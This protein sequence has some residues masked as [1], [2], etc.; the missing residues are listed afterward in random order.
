VS[1]PALPLRASLPA[2]PLRKLFE[3][4]PIKVSAPDPP[5]AFSM[6]ISL[7]IPSPIATPVV[8]LML[9]KSSAV[10]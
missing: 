7:S 10:E 1:L 2:P 3:E 6:E 4:L 5:A 8:R 9:R